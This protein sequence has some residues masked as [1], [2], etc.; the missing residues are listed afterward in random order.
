MVQL[1]KDGDGDHKGHGTAHTQGHVHPPGHPDKWT[2]AHKIVQ[3]EVIN[4]RGADSDQKN[5]DEV[6]HTAILSAGR[7]TI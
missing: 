7:W 5:I 2:D 3:H 6:I 1:K 4:Q